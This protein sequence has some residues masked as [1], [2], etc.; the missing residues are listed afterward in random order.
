MNRLSKLALHL[1]EFFPHPGY[2]ARL[3]QTKVKNI[4]KKN[5]DKIIS[6][7]KALTKA[8]I[9]LSLARNSYPAESVQSISIQKV[10]YYAQQL[11]QLLT[12]KEQLAI[13]L[14]EVDKQTEVFDLH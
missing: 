3:S 9:L 1:I 14:I 11:K 7:Q 2:L 4:L 6:D 5:T 13:Q 12:T 10:V 8:Q